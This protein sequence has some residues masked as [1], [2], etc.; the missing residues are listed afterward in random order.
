MNS[1]KKTKIKKIIQRPE[2]GSKRNVA[3]CFMAA[4]ICTM[5]IVRI[6]TFSKKKATRWKGRECVRVRVRRVLHFHFLQNHNARYALYYKCKYRIFWC[7]LPSGC[8]R[9]GILGLI[10]VYVFFF[11]SF[12]PFACTHWEKGRFGSEKL[13]KVVVKSSHVIDSLLSAHSNTH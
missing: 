7:I 8:F 11:S 2:V 9:I 5:D 3:L 10:I 12:F 1:E 13:S 4:L 6:L